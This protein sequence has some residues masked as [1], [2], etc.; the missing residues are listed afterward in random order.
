MSRRVATVPGRI[1]VM[2]MLSE[3]PHSRLKHGPA[4]LMLTEQLLEHVGGQG[5]VRP[6]VQMR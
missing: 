5:A 1:S 2:V 4:I 3:L 6:S